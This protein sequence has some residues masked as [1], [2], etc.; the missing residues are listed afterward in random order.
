MRPETT[1]A[2]YVVDS[3]LPADGRGN[4]QTN[5]LMTGL[6]APGV[7]AAAKVAA[8]AA[9]GILGWLRR[10]LRPDTS[11]TTLDQLA[12]NLAEA[13]KRR[14]ES[15]REQLRSGPDAVIDLT[16]HT[17]ATFESATTP[18]TGTLANS[19]P[20]YRSLPSKRL[21]ILG[22]PG[23]GKTVLANNLVLDQ[24]AQR[25]GTPA[26]QRNHTPVPVRMNLASWNST[27]PFTDWLTKRLALDYGFHQRESTALVT[28]GR[29]LPILDGL[30][31]MDPPEKDPDRGRQA[32]DRLNE[33]PW[34]NRPIILTC[35]AT[36]YTRIQQL[37]GDGGLHT[38][39]AIT[40]QPLTAPEITDYLDH[41]RVDKLQITSPDTW[42]PV[43]DEIRGHP[44]GP[45]ATALGAPWLL[46]LTAAS[47]H[48][49]K[50]T[51]TQLAHCQDPEAVQDALFAALIPA[52]IQGTERT[53]RTRSY[54][55]PNVQTWMHT[56]ATHLAHERH[57]EPPR[58]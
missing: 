42:A 45:L 30:D 3:H 5:C 33:P 17:Q 37:R 27:N 49:S 14:E 2:T 55:E 20:W 12:D 38:A 36:V 11:R 48:R 15:L 31:E 39:T 32:L 35:R 1:P 47:L 4:W 44:D 10:K 8:P 19:G 7:S 46:S 9:K 56:L 26:P 53:K 57:T 23:A 16:F 34:L 51:A 58:V 28:T 41:Y 40:L 13:V 18:N 6:E 52:A 22:E 29:I 54:T 43:T 21:V 24:L 50:P 25:E